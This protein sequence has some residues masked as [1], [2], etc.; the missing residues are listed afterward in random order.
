MNREEQAIRQMAHE[1]VKQCAVTDMHTHLYAENFGSLLLWG[2]DEL[3]TYHYLV[4][5]MFRHSAVPEE[6][7]WGWSKEQQ[8][9]H[10]FQTLFVDC[11]PVSEAAI[12]VV[13]ICQRLGMPIGSRSI[14]ALR[15]A[16]SK[17]S[18]SEHID[19]IFSLANIKQVVMT[20][21]PFDPLERP[22]WEGGGVRDSRFLAALRI[23]SLLLDWES[24]CPKLQA[25]GLAV[26]AEWG[27]PDGEHNIREARRFLKEWAVRMKAVYIAASLPGT[28]RYPDDGWSSRMLDE[29]VIPVCRELNLPLALMVGVKRQVNPVLRLAGDRGERTDIGILERLLVRHPSQRFMVTLLARENQHELAVLARKFRNLLPF[30]CW[31]FLH[32]E[33]MIA[34]MTRMRTELLGTAFVPQHSDCRVLEQLI[35]KWDYSRHTIAEVLAHQYIRLARAGWTVSREEMERDADEWFNRQFRTFAGIAP[36]REEGQGG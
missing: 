16:W 22:V 5:E 8:A 26:T 24:A 27:G 9:K 20:N 29:A 1:V 17:V 19:H 35:T 34:E 32:T 18:L 15:E 31:W 6:T 11:S 7:F 25:E 33:S 2:I 13:G 12:A 28:F 14:E 30:G 23:D 3:L 36:D 10:V 21:D 4:A